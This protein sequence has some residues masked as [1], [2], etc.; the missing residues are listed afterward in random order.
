[1]YAESREDFEKHFHVSFILRH[2]N[3][4]IILDIKLFFS[5]LE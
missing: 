5:T 4:S 2:T 1:M 3:L